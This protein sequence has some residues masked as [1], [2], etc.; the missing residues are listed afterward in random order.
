MQ[1]KPVRRHPVPSVSIA[2]ADMMTVIMIGVVAPSRRVDKPG[3]SIGQVEK[4]LDVGKR[5]A[6][7]ILGVIGF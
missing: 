1:K 3:K 6:C 2:G 4:V 5:G 7:D